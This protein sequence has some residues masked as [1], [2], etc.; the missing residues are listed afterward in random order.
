MKKDVHPK[1]GPITVT[2]S[3]GNSFET[4]SAL[5]NEALHVEVCD[6][7]HPFYTGKQKIVDV[8][9]RVKKFEERYSEK[10]DSDD[11]AE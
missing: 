1:Y 7:C 5:E 8:A 9:G 3:C 11:G 4:S 10:S 2:C 6:K